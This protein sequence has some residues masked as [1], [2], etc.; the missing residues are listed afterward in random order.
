M[1]AVD[2]VSERQPSDQKRQVLMT[3]VRIGK[4]QAPYLIRG[5]DPSFDI[6][7]ALLLGRGTGLLLSTERNASQS[8]T[9]VNELRFTKFIRHRT[10]QGAIGSQAHRGFQPVMSTSSYYGLLA[11]GFR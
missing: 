2:S 4:P 11:Q 1:K 5:L 6:L 3:P 9:I 7:L 8:V 10:I